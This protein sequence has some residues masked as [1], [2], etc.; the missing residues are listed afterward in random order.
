[1][2]SVDDAYDLVSNMNY[3]KEKGEDVGKWVKDPSKIPN[4]KEYLYADFANSLKSMGNKARLDSLEAGKNIH[5]DKEAAKTYSREIES[6]K[7]KL[8]EIDSYSPRERQAQRQ[9]AYV[10]RCKVKKLGGDYNALNESGELAKIKDQTIAYQR[11]KYDSKRPKLELT[12]KEWEA[13]SKNA[14]T[15]TMTQ[16]IMRTL[17]PDALRGWATPA[18]TKK[19]PA[20]KI[21]RMKRMLSLGYT[22]NEIAKALNISPSTVEEYKSK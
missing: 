10:V 17:T 5:Q 1:M 20:I 8:D 11:H 19:I 22:V 7:N 3:K 15:K 6:I 13:V 16:K 2:E 18:S 21:T 14:C 9:A 4:A 12:A